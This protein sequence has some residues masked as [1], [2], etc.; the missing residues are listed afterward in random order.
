VRRENKRGVQKLPAV[1]LPASRHV[2]QGTSS[3]AEVAMSSFCRIGGTEGEISLPDP[4]P[5]IEAPSGAHRPTARVNPT[6]IVNN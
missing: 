5:A 1:R 4:V 6:M 3:L 2:G